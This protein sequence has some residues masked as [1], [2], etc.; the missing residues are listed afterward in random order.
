MVRRHKTHQ[1]ELDASGARSRKGCLRSAVDKVRLLEDGFVVYC[2]SPY[3]LLASARQ[4]VCNNVEDLLA[5]QIIC[6]SSTY[7]CQ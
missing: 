1:N 6:E 7:A 2:F 3:R 4:A 5:N